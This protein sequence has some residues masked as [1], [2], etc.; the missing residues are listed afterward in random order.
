MS[1]N[2]YDALENRRSHYALSKETTISNTRIE[3]IVQHAVKHVPSA[4]N[5][6]ST[7]VVILFA[8]DHDTLWD[9]TT[10]ALK[11]VV[12]EEAD[13]SGTQQKMDAF[14][15]A[16]GTI[17]FFEDQDVVRGLQEQFPLYADNFPIWSIQ[18]SGMHQLAVWTGLATEGLGASL[19]HYNPIIDELVAEK[20]NIPNTWKLYAQMPFGKPTSDAGPKEFKPLDDRIKVHGS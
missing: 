18:T 19:Q 16:Y 11:G 4:F 7:R 13:F 20:W 5:S 8:K 15:G 10:D 17:L 12:G 2:F 6:Q 1:M 3:E 14:K 9:M